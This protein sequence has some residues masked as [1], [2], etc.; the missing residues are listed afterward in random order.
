LR[1]RR[2]GWARTGIAAETL[3][4]ERCRRPDPIRT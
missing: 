3:I 2:R 4:L 1:G